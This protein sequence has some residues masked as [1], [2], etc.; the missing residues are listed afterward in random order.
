MNAGKVSVLSFRGGFSAAGNG[1]REEKPMTD[2]SHAALDTRRRTHKHE[3]WEFRALLGLTYPLFLTAA[4]AERAVGLVTGAAPRSPGRS[5]FA[6]AQAA[7]QA[8][9]TQAF[10]G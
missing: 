8:S 9:L 4:I 6:E 7:A 2:I 5:V 10:M 3:L 1:F